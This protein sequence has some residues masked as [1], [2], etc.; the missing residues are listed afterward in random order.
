MT[1]H[2]WSRRGFAWLAAIAAIGIGA[3]VLAA[4]SASQ[5]TLAGAALGP[6]WQCSR[7]AFVMTS[8]TRTEP[9]NSERARVRQEQP[10]PG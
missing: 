2:L 9:A 10:S 3:A 7:I 5:E 1:N 4:G 8:C 6:D